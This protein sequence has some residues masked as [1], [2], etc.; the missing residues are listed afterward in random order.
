[1]AAK[2]SRG[3]LVILFINPLTNHSPDF[4]SFAIGAH[5]NHLIRLIISMKSVINKLGGFASSFHFFCLSF[6]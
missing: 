4:C 5:F 2:P 3:M 1:M 6:F